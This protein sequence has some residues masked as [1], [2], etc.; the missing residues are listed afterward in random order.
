ML[1][2]PPSAYSFA[3]EKLYEMKVTLIADVSA[4][5]KVLAAENPQHPVPEESVAFYIQKIIQTGNVVLGGKA[6]EI[7]EQHF[8]GVENTFPN[9]EVLLLSTKQIARPGFATVSTPEEAIQLLTAKGYT[10]IIIGG[11]T[12][13]YN[14]FLDKNLVTDIY[15]NIIPFVTGEGGILGTRDK[16]NTAFKR[17]SHTLLS[18]DIV[19]LH[20]TRA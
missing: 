4:N 6:F 20:L 17:V 15:L 3:I 2:I 7:I 8:G 13:T 16:L 1:L 5:G 12:L 10:E 18:D 19:Q 14:A 11:G 9:T